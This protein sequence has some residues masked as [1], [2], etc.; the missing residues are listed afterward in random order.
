MPRGS[1]VTDIEVM[2]IR[3][4]K[5]TPS[6]RFPQSRSRSQSGNFRSMN[7]SSAP[8]PPRISSKASTREPDDRNTQ[9]NRLQSHLFAP[10]MVAYNPQVHPSRPPKT[11]FLHRAQI[12]AQ[13][14]VHQERWSHPVGA[15]RKG[16]RRS[17]WRPSQTLPPAVRPPPTVQPRRIQ[18]NPEMTRGR[19]SD[20]FQYLPSSHSWSH[21]SMSAAPAMKVPML[22]E[23][24][25]G[26]ITNQ[27]PYSVSK[28]Q[29]PGV[30]R[31][32]S[33]ES[34]ASYRPED[35]S[36]DKNTSELS[37]RYTDYNDNDSSIP[38]PLRT[39]D[40]PSTVV[41]SRVELVV[42]SPGVP[43]LVQD[44]TENS[45]GANENSHMGKRTQLPRHPASLTSTPDILTDA[46]GR[47]GA[48]GQPPY[49][50]GNESDVS[51]E[52]E[53]HAPAMD[54]DMDHDTT[55]VQNSG[56]SEDEE[57]SV[58]PSSQVSVH[59]EESP[60]VTRPPEIHRVPLYKV[61]S[62]MPIPLPKARF[63][64]GRRLLIPSNPTEPIAWVSMPGDMQFIDGTSQ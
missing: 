6:Q 29:N 15:T 35:L 52:Y 27:Q 51:M 48:K 42:P 16:R 26:Q 58:G 41:G 34:G 19:P 4:N 56:S 59:R 13:P 12:Y 36:G 11:S 17:R 64:R 24:R 63:A 10:H 5:T 32:S 30:Y 55:E 9:R 57:S 21:A 25:Q 38:R 60:P 49:R 14:A 33:R 53:C 54:V 1:G 61:A 39:L 20:R 28:P 37:R 3:V 31:V 47:N 8:L 40:N 2:D 62:N 22:H 7:R 23:V 43:A 46:H 45:S 44:R 18:L 50:E